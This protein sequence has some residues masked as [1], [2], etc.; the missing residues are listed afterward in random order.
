MT[1]QQY[2]RYFMRV[3]AV[4]VAILV[5]ASAVAGQLRS[6]LE[7]V[8]GTVTA[9]DQVWFRF[10]LTN[11]GQ[12]DVSF[13]VYETPLKGFERDLLRVTREG[14]PI[15]YI[16]LLALRLGPA[17]ED[18]V[19]LAAGE[20]LSAVFDLATVYDLRRGGN[21]T[22]RFE[23]FVHVFRG[24]ETRLPVAALGSD[25]E[26]AEG[27]RR[28]IEEAVTSRELEGE[29]VVAPAAA[30]TIE[31]DV[32]TREPVDEE[33]LVAGAMAFYGCSD[34]TTLTTA[35]S[36]A[37]SRAARAYNAIPTYNTF[38]RTWFGTTS[39]YVST[40]RG[41]FANS[42][43]RL[44][45]TVDYYCG[46]YAPY[47]QPNYIAYTYKTTS[48]RIY[49]CGAFWSQSSSMKAHTIAHESFHWNTVAGADDVTYG[50]NNCLNL[51]S[52]RPYD[53]LRNA[54]NYAY[55]TTYAP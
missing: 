52:T 26:L 9:G 30:V 45:A 43:N 23:A 17:A 32:T 11:T 44:G 18:W 5:A 21:Y 28:G 50:Y 27:Y 42:Y 34:T 7:P 33:E 51:A 46:S 8:A 49:I 12:E 4:V 53:A 24:P 54:D 14:E 22:V 19:R 6:T 38:Y 39:S 47:C 20:S 35:E 1:F 48:N 36:T 2:R 40:V 31:G 15:P 10:T 55:A 25:G 41:R 37:R 29:L 13:L 3:A 16:G